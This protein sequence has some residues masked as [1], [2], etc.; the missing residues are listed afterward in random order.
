MSALLSVCPAFSFLKCSCTV[1]TNRLL[2]SQAYWHT[3]NGLTVQCAFGWSNT[4]WILVGRTDA[5]TE[6]PVFCSSN[7]NRRLIGKVP[8]AG[9]DWGQKEKRASEDKMA[10]WHHQCNEH[11]LGQTLGGGERQGGL[12]CCSPCGSKESDTTGLLN[13]N[14]NFMKREFFLDNFDNLEIL[15]VIF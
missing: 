1:C 2:E 7:V 9:K 10:G 5:E 6:T 3:E 4:I 11:G 14:N 15:T 13:N 12:A 8:D